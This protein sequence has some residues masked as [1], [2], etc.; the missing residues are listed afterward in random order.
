MIEAGVVALSGFDDRFESDA[1]A[2][3]DIFRAMVRA[4]DHRSSESWGRRS[5]P[6]H[7]P[8]APSSAQQSANKR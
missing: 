3:A 7:S 2:V 1:D 4:R 6:L 5:R 8:A